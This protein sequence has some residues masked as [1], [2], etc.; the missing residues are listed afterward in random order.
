MTNLAMY[1]VDPQVV[2]AG[3][4][5]AFLSIGALALFGV[6]LPIATWLGTRQKEREAYYKSETLRRIV[7][8]PGEGG[9]AA[10]ELLREQSRMERIKRREGMKIG[11][12]IT[13]GVGIALSIFLGAQHDSGF[14]VGLIPAFVGLALLVYVFFLAAPI[15]EQPKL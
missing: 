3:G 8:A 13:L 11:G 15:D 4:V 12:L 14:L 1:V 10:V 7:E 2:E 5:F 6:F 9:K